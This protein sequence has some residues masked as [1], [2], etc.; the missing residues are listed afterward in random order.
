MIS[1]WK[2]MNCNRINYSIDK[3]HHVLD[4]CPCGRS[5]VDME[6]YGCRIGGDVKCLAELD[7][8]FFDEI[9]IGM[10]EQGFELKKF[11]SKIL[12]DYWMY[13]DYEPV[14]KI[15]DKIIKDLLKDYD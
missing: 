9:L 13:T 10:K 1:I 4:S 14:R 15:E 11:M 7:Y 5:F 6:T 8:N 3:R 2:C 12:G